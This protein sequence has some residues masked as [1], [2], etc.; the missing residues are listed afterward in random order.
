MRF[1]PSGAEMPDQPIAEF[2]QRSR[3]RAPRRKTFSRKRGSYG[4]R[5]DAERTTVGYVRTT[6]YS[7]PY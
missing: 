2:V 5:H 6:C 4:L 3:I 7:R 1:K